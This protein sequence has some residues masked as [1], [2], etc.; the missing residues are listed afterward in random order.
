M[1]I[2]VVSSDIVISLSDHDDRWNSPKYSFYQM[3]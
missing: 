3:K 2:V 1:A